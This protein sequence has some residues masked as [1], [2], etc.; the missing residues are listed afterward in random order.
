MGWPQGQVGVLVGVGNGPLPARAVRP[1]RHQTSLRGP[2]VRRGGRTSPSQLSR[3]RRHLIIKDDFRCVSVTGQYF[4]IVAFLGP[5]RPRGSGV[6]LSS[7]PSPRPPPLVGLWFKPHTYAP[8]RSPV[9][10]GLL[11]GVPRVG[12][13]EARD[14]VGGGLRSKTFRP[15]RGR[16]EGGPR[17][18]PRVGPGSRIDS[19]RHP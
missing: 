14:G 12:W 8:P 18:G 4:V 7:G 11:P 6:D 19:T 9:R 1:V 2:S 3:R 13:Y 16:T 17:G 10:P 15:G 5:F